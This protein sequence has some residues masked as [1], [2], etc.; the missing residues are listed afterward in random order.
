[1]DE[2]NGPHGGSVSEPF[3]FIFQ[4]PLSDGRD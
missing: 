3:C 2:L 1:V 4:S